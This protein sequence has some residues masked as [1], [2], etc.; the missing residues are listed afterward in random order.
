MKALNNIGMIILALWL[1]AQ[2]MVTMFQI[3]NPNLTVALPVLAILAG[4]MILLRLRES[5]P[6][7]SLGILLLSVWLILTGI[8]PI[9]HAQSTELALVMAALGLAAGILILVAQ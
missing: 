1:V 8:I 5:K 6:L 4:V 2:G 7:V 9:L 3:N